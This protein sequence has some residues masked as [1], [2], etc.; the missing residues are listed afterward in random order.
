[1]KMFQKWDMVMTHNLVM[2]LLNT[3]GLYTYNGM[4]CKFMYNFMVCK[5]YFNKAVKKYSLKTE[6]L[7]VSY[8]IV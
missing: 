7:I 5:L 4:G 8:S 2:H 3:T 1:M 6:F